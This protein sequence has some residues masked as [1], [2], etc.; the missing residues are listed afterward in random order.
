[1]VSTCCGDDP[2]VAEETVRA[3]GEEV[4]ARS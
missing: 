4:V 3:F 1:V 2:A